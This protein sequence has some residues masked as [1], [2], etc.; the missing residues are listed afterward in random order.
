LGFGERTARLLIAGANRKPASDLNEADAIA[1]SRQI[2][3]HEN[4][5]A[6]GTGENEWYTPKQYIEAARKVLGEIDLD[7]ATS[8]KAQET[9]GAKC[10]SLL[11][12]FVSEILT[13]TRFLVTSPVSGFL[14][15]LISGDFPCIL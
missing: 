12:V 1:I 2:W 5:R 7:P 15:A 11:L 8:E 13:L 4:H 9:I 3:G 6:L 14:R 10:F